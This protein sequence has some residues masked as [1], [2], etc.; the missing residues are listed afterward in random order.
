MKLESKRLKKITIVIDHFFKKDEFYSFKEQ[1]SLLD[2]KNANDKLTTLWYKF[3]E[4]H[5]FFKLCSSL[6]EE[7]KNYYDFS[8]AVGYEF[9]TQ[10]NTRPPTL[11]YDRDEKL[12]NEKKI[13]SFPICS[14]IFYVI[15]DNLSGGNLI[16][17][18]DVIHPKENRLVIFPPGVLHEVEEFQGN[19]TSVLVNPWNTTLY[20]P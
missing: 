19:R 6:L 5:Q 9:W 8:S 10:N 16:L 2:G 15:V 7:A 14:I 11:H 12:Y 4:N 13:F 3:G 20:N 1:I 17:D 18:S